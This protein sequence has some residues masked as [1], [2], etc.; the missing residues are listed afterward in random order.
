MQATISNPTLQIGSQ[1]AKVKELQQLLNSRSS[2]DYQLV[3]DGI[4]GAKT[5]KMVKTMQRIYFLKIDGIVDSLTWKALN[6]NAPVDTP[7]LRRGSQGELV[8][9]LQQALV[10]GEG[11]LKLAIDGIFGSQTE[12]AVKAFQRRVAITQ[13]G[14]VGPKTWNV[15]SV[16]L[17]GLTFSM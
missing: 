2:R 5:E 8:K 12:A 6:T 1:G 10:E 14:I 11:Q 9:R 3:V 16:K 17:A 7:V 4:F 15:L 13:D